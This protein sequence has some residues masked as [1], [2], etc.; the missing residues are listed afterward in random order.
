MSIKGLK[1]TGYNGFEYPYIALSPVDG[2]K[3]KFNNI[4]DVY[5]ELLNCYE[6]LNEKNVTNISE[7]IYIEHFYFAN[8]SELIDSKIQQRIKEYNFCKAFSVP[9]YGSLNDTPA[10]VVDDFMEIEYIMSD[11]AKEKSNG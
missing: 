8:T 10:K 3:K 7:T 11:V 4:E 2:K 5:G 1:G 6:E 9:P